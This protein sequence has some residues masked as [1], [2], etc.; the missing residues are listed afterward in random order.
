MIWY[1]MKI[2]NFFS[3]RKWLDKAG[4]KLVLKSHIQIVKKKKKVIHWMFFPGITGNDMNDSFS[5]YFRALTAAHVWDPPP[6][7]L[8]PDSPAQSGRDV[9]GWWPRGQ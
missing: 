4:L 7:P 5:H 1:E 3:S 8:C 9:K 2:L 6:A